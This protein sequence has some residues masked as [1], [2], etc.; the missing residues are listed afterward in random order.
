MEDPLRLCFYKTFKANRLVSIHIEF[1]WEMFDYLEESDYNNL[2]LV[3]KAMRDGVN[4]HRNR[5]CK[6]QELHVSDRENTE[7]VY[8]VYGTKAR[9]RYARS[10]QHFQ[11]REDSGEVVSKCRSI[12]FDNILKNSWNTLTCA[13]IESPHLNHYY[14]R[15]SYLGLMTSLSELHLKCSKKRG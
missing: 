12:A 6:T 15:T 9:Y 10:H 8:E 7:D 4:V 13:V 2:R 5:N 11:W 14:M 3:C 1:V